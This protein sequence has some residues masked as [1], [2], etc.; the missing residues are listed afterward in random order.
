MSTSQ[1]PSYP[2]PK[3]AGRPKKTVTYKCCSCGASFTKQEG[4]FLTSSS[5]LFEANNG[6]VPFCKTCAENYYKDKLLPSLDFDEARAIEVFCSIC[7]WYYS[8]DAL[9]MSQKL[10][11]SQPNGILASIYGG[12]RRL[13]QV[14]CRGETYLDTILQRREA[15]AKILTLD[16]AS[17]KDVDPDANHIE[18]PP[19]IFKMFG[20][21]YT[22]EE[23]EYLA[24]QHEDWT[25][26][27]EI[28]TKALEIC[29]QSLCVSQLNIRRAQQ[30]N[31]QKA[32]ADAMKSFQEML[33]TAKLSPK[34]SKTDEISQGATFGE[35]IKVWEDNAPI[36]EPAPEFRD[37]DGI[38]KLVTVFF[39]G[40][41]CKMFNIKNDYSAM[42]DEEVSKYTV[43][44]PQ[45]EED[46]EDEDT[47]TEALFR[48]ARNAPEQNKEEQG[49]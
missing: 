14:Q 37:V 22:P 35:L 34:Q 32:A 33:T 18:I 46:F 31:N 49:D 26:R 42:Y 19:E 23:Y 38:K 2:K 5:S 9:T 25:S 40:H 1:M 20:P 29:I 17:G 43:T 4:N 28:N 21:G 24:E 30:E 13:R 47:R 45:S 39:F 16:E 41:L 36:P 44:R 12:R 8:E 7:D 15:A 11:E 10:R 3:K 6:Y 27:Y 48:E